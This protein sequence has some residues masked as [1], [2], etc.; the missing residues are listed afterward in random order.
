MCSSTMLGMLLERVLKEGLA[1]KLEVLNGL[2]VCVAQL[3]E[4][5]GAQPA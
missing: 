4:A 2:L 1:L 5:Q 3:S